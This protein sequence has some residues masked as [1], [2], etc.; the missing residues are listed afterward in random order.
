MN[1]TPLPPLA[2]I[3]SGT[4]QCESLSS[5]VQR[6]AAAQC[7]L[8]GQLVFRVLT[9]MDLGQPEMIGTWA[10]RSGRVRIGK[11]IN[12]FS[13]AVVWLT[14]IQRL[15]GRAD[16]EPATTIAWDRLFPTRFFQRT[17]LAWC[18]LCLAEDPEPYH[19]LSWMLQCTKICPVHRTP[20]YQRCPTCGN[21]IAVLHDRSSVLMCPKCTGDLRRFAKPQPPAEISEYDLW[22]ADEIGKII[23]A[24]KKWYRPLEWTPAITLQQLCKKANLNDAAEFARFIGTSKVTTWYWLNGKARPSLPF[25]LHICYR[26]RVSLAGLLE[27]QENDRLKLIADGQI[28]FHLPPARVKRKRNWHNIGTFLQ[29]ELQKPIDKAI[30]LES[31]A[32]QTKTPVRTLRN[33]FPKLCHKLAKKN[34]RRQRTVARL[35]NKNLEKDIKAAI[36]KLYKTKPIITK[37][38]IAA[39]LNKPGLFSRHNARYILQKIKNHHSP[40]FH[41]IP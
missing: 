6:L 33:H 8:P 34:S 10:R 14:L 23:T 11:N 1:I 9:W 21:G 38:N 17:R 16:L 12:G 15:T 36:S 4:P 18:P 37:S 31:I 7:I 25:T 3:H 32:K 29:S 5:Y 28:E 24:S 19:R 35:R 20:L 41:Q 27:Q 39:L 2:P 26:F 22:V 13:L 30:P 40:R